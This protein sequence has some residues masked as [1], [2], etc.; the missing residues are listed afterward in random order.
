MTNLEGRVAL[1]TGASR[2]IGL[3]I[4][5]RLARSKAC[6]A[7]IARGEEV[8]AAATRLT[9]NGGE[10]RGYAVD[11]TDLEAMKNVAQRIKESLGPV[12]ILVNNAGIAES[13][14]S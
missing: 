1:V 12:D 14:S 2:G 5:D 11:L 4:A 7:M 9:S 3:A 10:V 6:V 13:A 8:S